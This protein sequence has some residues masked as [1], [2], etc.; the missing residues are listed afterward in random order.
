[1]MLKQYDLDRL[2]KLKADIDTLNLRFPVTTIAK[3]LSINKGNVS[4]YLNEKLPLTQKFIDN[5]YY[6][7]ETDLEQAIRNPV[8]EQLT[9]EE[10]P[11]FDTSG[12]RIEILRNI[13][14]RLSEI[15]DL[16]KIFVATR[17]Q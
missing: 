14:N 1:M 10:R 15:V 17:D 5:F 4:S 2:K 12:E 9:V 16:L 8:Q 6:N 3:R 13:A 11:V 7:F